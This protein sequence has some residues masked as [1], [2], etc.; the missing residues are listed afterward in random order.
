MTIKNFPVQVILRRVIKSAIDCSCLPGI[1]LEHVD[2]LLLHQ[3]P[4]TVVI[5]ELEEGAVELL[6]GEELL[7]ALLLEVSALEQGG[8][9]L[10]AYLQTR[11]PGRLPRRLDLQPE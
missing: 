2:P 4:V 3:E 10:P 7:E 11:V 8:D 1:F 5:E 6:V 9:P